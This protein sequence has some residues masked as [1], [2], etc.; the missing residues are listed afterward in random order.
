LRIVVVDSSRVVLRIITALLEPRGHRVVSFTDSREAL[1]FV[2]EDVSVEAVITSLETRPIGGIELCWQLRLIANANRPICIIAMSSL[3]NSRNLSEALDSGADDFIS[4]PPVPEELHARL[5]A[6]QR[7]MTMQQ[8]LIRL[9][10]FDALTSLLNRRAFI[11]RLNAIR[12]AH[13]DC[14]RRA[15]TLVL[16]DIDNF[17]CLND[18]Y[19]H[20]VGDE[21]LRRTGGVFAE[22]AEAEDG[23]AAR[24]GG[25]EFVLALP[26]R[27]IEDAME[28]ADRLRRA[29]SRISINAGAQVVR[30]T[31]SFG[32]GEW[33]ADETLE[34]VFKRADTAL[35]RA[36]R[37]GRDRVVP[38]AAE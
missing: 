8:D 34:S 9:A 18:S 36:K 20:D 16:A 27:G 4:K 35:Y 15:P 5:R 12:E 33:R 38:A 19:G 37:S 31:S 23:V 28:V 32:V 17:K 30:F 22:E 3:A 6:G 2:R 10:E 25:E 21:A 13:G 24:F 26:G 1:D 11:S 7:L 14:E 29:V